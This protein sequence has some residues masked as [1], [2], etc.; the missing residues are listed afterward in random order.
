MQ[1]HLT[2]NSARMR[3][4]ASSLESEPAKGRNRGLRHLILLGV[5]F[6]AMV[7]TSAAEVNSKTVGLGSKEVETLTHNG[8]IVPVFAPMYR[9]MG[10]WVEDVK[11]LDGGYIIIYAKGDKRFAISGFTDPV[12]Y[13]AHRS[14]K[15]W[16]VSNVQLGKS[17][18]HYTL[19]MPHGGPYTTQPALQD[20]QSKAYYNFDGDV[21]SA[22]DAL[23]IV[24]SIRHVQL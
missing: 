11:I 8:Y 19:N 12:K 22:Q 4:R 23:K 3:I 1:A 5:L 16:P 24:K 18:V 9:P 15:K 21:P 10:Y 17:V 14:E 2:A 20:P 7:G 13:L 6:L